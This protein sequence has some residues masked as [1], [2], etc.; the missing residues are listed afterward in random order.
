[1]LA[2]TQEYRRKRRRMTTLSMTPM[3]MRDLLSRAD[4]MCEELLLRITVLESITREGRP[5]IPP[6]RNPGGTP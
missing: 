2:K 5:T 3:A 1:M 4:E 6:T